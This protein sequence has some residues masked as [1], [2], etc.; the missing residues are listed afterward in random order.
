[1]VEKIHHRVRKGV[2]ISNDVSL[3]CVKW[4]GKHYFVI[5]DS[6]MSLVGTAWD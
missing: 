2:Q 4:N 3:R 1:M 5:W 6:G